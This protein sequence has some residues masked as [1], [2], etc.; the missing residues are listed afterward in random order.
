MPF[1]K[2]LIFQILLAMAVHAVLQ[3]V[4]AFAAVR[5]KTKK[6]A[7]NPGA[8][9]GVAPGDV[10]EKMISAYDKLENDNI[11]LTDEIDRRSGRSS[12]IGAEYDELRGNVEVLL[13]ERADFKAKIEELT[14][15]NETYKKEA[16]RALEYKKEIEEYKNEIVDLRDK[17]A[18]LQGELDDIKMK[19][20]IAK[21]KI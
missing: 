9:A 15:R 20:R 13:M 11:M 19:G 7:K 21:D 6:E 1:K 12:D 3:P 18:V 10:F 14:L 4:T 17:V 2:V 5:D 8:G 16:Q